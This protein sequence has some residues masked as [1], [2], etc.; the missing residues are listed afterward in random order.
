MNIFRKYYQEVL[1]IEKLPII[2]IH[3]AEIAKKLHSGLQNHQYFLLSEINNYHPDYLGQPIEKLKKLKFSLEDCK[4]TIACEYGFSSWQQVEE[5][6]NEKYNM[7]F[8]KA[9]NCIID[10]DTADLEYWLSA[11]P[12]LLHQTSQYGHQATL[13]HYTASNGVEIWRQSSPPNLG[14]ITTILLKNG[15]K[16]DATMKIYGGRFTALELFTTSAHPYEAG[17]GKV[18]ELLQ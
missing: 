10:G 18:A 11:Q 13:L 14:E 7:P 4:T 6:G 8:E 9:V 3:L 17:V 5:L 2:R 12:Q 16:K 1:D 15:A